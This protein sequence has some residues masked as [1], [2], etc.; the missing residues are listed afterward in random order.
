MSLIRRSSDAADAFAADGCRNQYWLMRLPRMGSRIAAILWGVGVL[1]SGCGSTKGGAA[2]SDTSTSSDA[3]TTVTTSV[4]VPATSPTSAPLPSSTSLATAEPSTSTF[5]AGLGVLSAFP[6]APTDVPT[7]EAVPLLLPAAPVSGATSAWRTES[8]DAAAPVSDFVQTWF[9]AASP[10][11]VL[12]I[13]T[14]PGE[15]AQVNGDPV[16]V[17]P[18]D[19]AIIGPTGPGFAVVELSDASGSV[20]LWSQGLFP[21][22]LID[23][24]RGMT[25][26][27]DGGPGWNTPVMPAGLRAVHEGWILGASS[28]RVNWVN[29]NAPVAEMTITHGIPTDFTTPTGATGTEFAEIGGHLAVVYNLEARAAVVW[30]PAADVTVVFA[31][32]GTTHDALTVARTVT[33]TDQAP[34]NAASVPG[35]SNG[36]GCGDSW[37]C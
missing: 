24:A 9:G 3:V 16:K 33:S 18:W 15:S 17:S 14:R 37:F 26:R 5:R 2:R 28:R 10:P 34:W 8:A 7:L 6:R 29:G 25:L 13:D 32:V 31:I 36:D 21:A 19:H 23:I 20:T 27:S 22:D 30:S 12:T 1:V 35:T 11:V 4:T